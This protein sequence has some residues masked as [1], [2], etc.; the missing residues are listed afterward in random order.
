MSTRPIRAYAAL[1]ALTL[2][3][4][5]SC[6]DGNAPIAPE[7]RG[8]GV[9]LPISAAILPQGADAVLP[10]I[11]RIRA[12]A[13]VV[14]DG[15]VLGSVVLDVSP[16]AES[17][18][19]EIPVELGSLPSASVVVTF[20]LISVSPTGPETVE[21]AGKTEPIL[22]RAGSDNAPVTLPLVRGG[23]GNLQV[24]AVQITEPLA[25]ILEGAG[26]TLQAT[27][28]TSDPS[29]TGTVF[30]SPLDPQ[31]VVNGNVATGALP[32]TARIVAT[33][34]SKAD[35]AV[36]TVRARPA[37]VRVTPDSQTVVGAGVVVTLAG[38]VLDF[39][40]NPIAGQPV[41]WR[42][43]TPTVLEDQGAGSF[44]S[45]APGRG[46]AEARAASDTTLKGNGIV[47]VTRAA[48]DVAVT[49][50]ASSG[51]AF[52]GDTVRFT[53]TA[54]NRGEIAA[55]G[56]RVTDE[57]PNGLTL[58][59]TTPSVGTFT[60]GVWSVG[61]LAAGASATLQL[62]ATVNTG[63]VGSTL[64]N[65]V[66]LQPLAD[67]QDRDATNDV[68][69]AAVTVARKTADLALAKTA[70]VA[71]LTEGDT[72]SFTIT[73]T[74]PGP[75]AAGGVTVV[76]SLPVGLVYLSHSNSRGAFETSSRTWNV[77]DVAVGATETLVL[78]TRVSGGTNGTTLQNRARI[79]AMTGAIDPNAG[80]DAASA[81]VTV[82]RNQ[83]DIAVNKASN[84][85]NATP[86]DTVRFT[87]TIMN[88][89]SVPATNIVVKDTLGPYF[90]LVAVTPSPGLVADTVARELRVASLGG[91]TSVTAV[92]TVVIAGAAPYITMT[93]T[94]R[95]T[96]SQPNDPNAANDVAT[97]SVT[98][99]PPPV[100][101]LDLAVAKSVAPA[102]A[103]ERGTVTFTV[104]VRNNGPAV[105]DN[106][107]ALDPNN[108]EGDYALSV[109]LSSYLTPSTICLNL[110]DNDIQ[111]ASYA[112]WV[113]QSDPGVFAIQGLPAPANAAA[114]YT[115]LFTKNPKF[116]LLDANFDGSGNFVLSAAACPVP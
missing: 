68:A 41:L 60:A 106:T 74:N 71:N 31:A 57:L 46:I 44:R 23:L 100:P 93:N 109:D 30:W 78:R 9:R 35:T 69:I 76:D 110:R 54:A 73:V 18:S 95:R 51:T 27:V 4:V 85:A 67:Q 64:T 28:T 25:A 11:N 75:Y 115:Y 33:A 8:S 49:K 62:R 114:A 70:V 63:T 45:A 14:P 99:G 91:G 90:R 32:G 52:E 22:V 19:V 102:V 79:I 66:R 13:R 50:T 101:K 48:T 96:A 39:R 98:V 89:S 86:G 105:A 37:S 10:T 20:E 59:S 3:L 56:V 58:V 112:L 36:L 77:G 61:D 97:A 116:N 65:T 113:A 53:I 42:T 107:I 81:S 15:I 7:G 29:L 111:A 24:T 34:G 88:A 12:V 16:G 55:A 40:G 80:N 104:T 103:L 38:T 17:W 83:A 72:A 84:R 94:A 1:A 82:S 5:A 108:A 87:V 43:L 2:L 92:Y 21:F 6:V 47:R 26:T